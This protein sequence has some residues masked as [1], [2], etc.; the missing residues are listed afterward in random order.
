MGK[1]AH[2]HI[3]TNTCVNHIIGM[4]QLTTPAIPTIPQLTILTKIAP[5]GGRLGA[6]TC[7]FTVSQGIV[8]PCIIGIAMVFVFSPHI[9]K[10]TSCFLQDQTYPP[11]VYI[12]LKPF[13]YY[14]IDMYWSESCMN[15]FLIPIIP[16]VTKLGFCTIC[17]DS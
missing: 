14:S 9:W 17:I 3:R 15:F 13:Y 2:I 1:S 5:Q 8:V 6:R 16:I 11:N 7:I 12:N 10:F 4:A